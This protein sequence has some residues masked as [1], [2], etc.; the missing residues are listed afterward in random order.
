MKKSWCILWSGA[1]Y[2]PG[3]TV[4][5]AT[6]KAYYVE[7]ILNPVPHFSEDYFQEMQNKP[8]NK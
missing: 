3:N 2:G 8:E 7:P 6:V 5:E 1:S 4:Y